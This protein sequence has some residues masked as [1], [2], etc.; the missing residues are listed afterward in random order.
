MSSRGCPYSCIFCCE[1]K[2]KGYKFRA[3]SA[4]SI[5]DEIE[6]LHND[7]DINHI[8]FYDSS[9]MI[10]Q[11][12]VERICHALIEK[13]LDI[14]WRAR[15][16]A[17]RVKEPLL[18][19]MKESGCTTLAIGAE[20]GSQRLLDT[21]EK[22]CT[23]EQIEESFRIAKKVG[24]WTVGYFMFGIPGETKADSMETIEFAKRLDPDWALFAHSTP[25]PGTKLYLITSKAQLLSHWVIDNEPAGKTR[26]YRWPEIRFNFR[27][28]SA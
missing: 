20:T 2:L 19:L 3:R 25:L 5:V 21:L 6:V 1:A 9:F 4:A 15:I 28:V 17:D 18:R 26:R 23:I 13:K 11:K 14:T 22:R 10:N 16:R 12:R 7:Y 24:L 27:K 8:V